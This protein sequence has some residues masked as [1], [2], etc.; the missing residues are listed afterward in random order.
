MSPQ[1]ANLEKFRDIVTDRL[2]RED[3]RRLLTS[4][5][6]SHAH[7]LEKKGLFP[8]RR[9][10]GNRSVCWKLSELLAWIDNQPK[11]GE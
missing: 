4:I 9:K 6:R 7:V 1:T 5:S 8:S 11:A 10:L 3:E 2:V